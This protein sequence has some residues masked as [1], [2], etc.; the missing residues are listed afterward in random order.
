MKLKTKE[1]KRV[2]GNI[3]GKHLRKKT[4]KKSSVTVDSSEDEHQEIL[5]AERSNDVCLEV[6]EKKKLQMLQNTVLQLV[7]MNKGILFKKLAGKEEE[8]FSLR[9]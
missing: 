6:S 2:K 4:I 1:L 7:M 9:S 3:Q 8:H 5:Y